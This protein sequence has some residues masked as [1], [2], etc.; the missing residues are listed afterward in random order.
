V[1]RTKQEK[2]ERRFLQ[3]KYL[4][5]RHATPGP[6]S[7]TVVLDHLKPDFNVGKIFR[8]ADAFGAKEICLVGMT[9]FDPSPAVGSFKHIP[10][11]FH[12]SFGE[13]HAYL[14]AQGLAI[15]RLEPEHGGLL[16]EAPV[17]KNCA[18]VLGN[19]GIGHSFKREDFPD[20]IS[21]RIPQW[22]RAQSLNVS[23]AAAVAMYEHC[24]RWG[25]EAPA[26]AMKPDRLRDKY[27]AQR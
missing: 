4:N 1:S 14:K 20:V 5:V 8:T 3:E 18:L 12:A 11:K 24:R 27:P 2:T 16:T 13:C 26:P 22:G 15:Y 6:Q 9:W 23:V 7:F 25:G 21:L 17:E 10:A 19:E